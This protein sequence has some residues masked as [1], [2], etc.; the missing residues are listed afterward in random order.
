MQLPDW[1]QLLGGLLGLVA[2]VAIPIMVF[3]LKGWLDQAEQTAAARESRYQSQY[4][5][6]R[7]DLSRVERETKDNA[8]EVADK[9]GAL[10]EQFVPRRELLAIVEAIRQSSETNLAYLKKLDQQIVNLTNIMLTKE[11]GKKNG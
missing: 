4:D 8:K 2:A 10:S 11:E 3:L 6:V 7:Q 1:V 9:F 5:G